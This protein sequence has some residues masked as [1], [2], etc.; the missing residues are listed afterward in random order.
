MSKRNRILNFRTLSGTLINNNTGLAIDMP[1]ALV[2]IE[3]GFDR[4]FNMGMN[5]F[6]LMQ[7]I[8]HTDRGQSAK[9]TISIGNGRSQAD[10]LEM[11]FLRTFETANV[12]VPYVQELVVGARGQTLN[13]TDNAYE[14]SAAVSGQE[15][16]NLLADSIQAF[17][18]DDTTGKAVELTQET[19]TVS[20]A[21]TSDQYMQGAARALRFSTSLLGRTIKLVGSET[22]STLRLS[23]TDPGDY[24]LVAK[25]IR[26][27]DNI[28]GVFEA[29][30]WVPDGAAAFD[31]SSDMLEIAGTFEYTGENGCQLPYD[32]Y[33]PNDA[34]VCLNS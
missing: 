33:M 20:G 27:E 16:F 6:G 8:S 18:L 34:Q 21:V 2:A 5:D 17:R 25:A 30:N 28:R 11:I 10:V 1:P 12:A 19:Y 31:P 26:N 7:P 3:T 32:F 22:K 13:A 24:R 23:E 14:V 15:G 4:Q 29:F 9:A